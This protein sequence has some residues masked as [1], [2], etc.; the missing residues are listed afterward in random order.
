MSAKTF[1]DYDNYCE[2]LVYGYCR[3]ENDDIPEDILRLCLLWFN[4][5]T[6]C[7]SCRTPIGKNIRIIINPKDVVFDI[8]YQIYEKEGIPLEKQKLYLPSLGKMLK[9]D[10]KVYEY[11]LHDNDALL[12]RLA[13]RYSNQN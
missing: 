10:L 7:L 9:D 2:I 5:N 11:N 8:K 12:L 13:I 1:K 4:P 3:N 6:I